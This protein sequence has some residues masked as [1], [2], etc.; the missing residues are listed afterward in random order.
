[1]LPNNSS[2]T[3]SLEALLEAVPKGPLDRLG[4]LNVNA[5]LFFVSRSVRIAK[6]KHQ[7]HITQ[8]LNI[9]FMTNQSNAEMMVN[10]IPA[11]AVAA[12]IYA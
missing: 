11:L 5:Q 3:A 4:Y 1:M 10:I 9:T 6:T 2:A 7:W 12:V 8:N